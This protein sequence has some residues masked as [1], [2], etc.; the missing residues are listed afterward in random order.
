[1]IDPV[2]RVWL[3][4]MLVAVASP[5]QAQPITSRDYAIELH[6]GVAIGDSSQTAMGGAGAARSLGSAGSL[7]NP[8][9]SAIRRETDNDSWSWDYHL[10]ILTGQFSS[11]YD[12]NGTLQRE[13]SGAN[14]LTLGLALRFGKW[15]GSLTGT[16]Q[17]SPVDG[18][19]P[20]LD[21]TT[22]RVRL[23]LARFIDSWDVA[24]G[25]GVQTV[26]FGLEPANP[27]MPDLFAVTGSGALVGATWVPRGERFRA[28]LALESRILGATIETQTCD[29]M[30]CDGYI[31]PEAIESPGRVILGLAYRHAETPW[32]QQVPKK[33]RDERSVTVAA[34]IVVTGSSTDGHGL[35]AFGMQQLQRTGRHITFSPRLGAEA[36]LLPGRLRVRG[37]TYWEPGRFD[38]VAGRVHATFGFEVRALEFKLWGLRRGKLGAIVDVARRYRNLGLS[39]GFW[40]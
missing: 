7:L 26:R 35:E 1:M 39:I 4:C 6:E 11:D 37:G 19:N 38:D 27:R 33:F 3:S 15:A 23:S 5:S 24:L 34:D 25:V 30:N 36:E 21:A 28:A 32:N 20:P 22:L 12:N 9:A 8:A 17:T 18:S 29:P 2:L 10:D 16:G 31:L 13:E 14:L 40:H